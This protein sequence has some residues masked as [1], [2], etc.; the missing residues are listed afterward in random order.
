MKRLL[1]IIFISLVLLTGCNKVKEGNASS[2][3]ISEEDVDFSVVKGTE[4]RIG[5]TCSLENKGRKD[6]NYNA[7]Y[8]IEVKRG[9]VWVELDVEMSFIDV[10][11]NLEAGLKTEIPFSW[12]CCYGKLVNGTYRIV[13]HVYFEGEEWFYIGCE[14]EV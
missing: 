5:V 11:Y 6:L 7:Y 13:K 14:F 8:T 10:M 4:S 12:D 9:D 2:I 3:K 1:V